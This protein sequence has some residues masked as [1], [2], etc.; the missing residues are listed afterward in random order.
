MRAVVHGDSAGVLGAVREV[1]VMSKDEMIAMLQRELRRLA[2]GDYH[3]RDDG[4]TVA[5]GLP[6]GHGG[7]CREQECSGV[8]EGMDK[9]AAFHDEVASVPR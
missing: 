9:Q 5:C 7:P 8:L 2:C 1:Q 4:M 3:V 6:D